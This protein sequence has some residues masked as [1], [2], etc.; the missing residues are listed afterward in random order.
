[1]IIRVLFVLLQTVILFVLQTG[2]FSEIALA[3]VVPDLLLILVIS[4]AFMRGRIPA[5]LTGM[6]AGLMMDC[7]YCSVIGIFALFY[8]IIGYLA[9]YSHKVYDEND[10]TIPLVLIGAGELLFNLM[11]FIV[12]LLLDGKLNLGF[13]LVRF[14][15]PK[16]IYTVLVS[17]VFYKLFN[18]LNV[19]MMRFDDN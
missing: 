9:G 14:M 16:V 8:M 4:V 7:T 13:Y 6:V 3:G 2:V 18:V 17:I 1:M 11:Y 12:F 5:M 15:F 19:Y 10:Y